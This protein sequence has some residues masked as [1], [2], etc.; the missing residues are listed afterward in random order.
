[1]RYTIGV[2]QESNMGRMIGISL[3]SEIC[4][5]LCHCHQISLGSQDFKPISGKKRWEKGEDEGEDR[6]EK[7]V[8]SSGVCS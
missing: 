5:F 4:S 3:V 6:K 2:L 1:M 8:V 7:N